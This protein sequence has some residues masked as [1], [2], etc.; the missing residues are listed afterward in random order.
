MEIYAAHY[1]QLVMKCTRVGLL[2]SPPRT[3]HPWRGLVRPQQ[4]PRPCR[5][6][7]RR[8][9]RASPHA[10]PRA[11]ML[12]FLAVHVRQRRILSRQWRTWRGR[13]WRGCAGGH[14]RT[15][16]TRTHPRRASPQQRRRG[17][18]GVRQALPAAWRD[19]GRDAYRAWRFACLGAPSPRHHTRTDASQ[20]LGRGASRLVA[21]P[22]WRPRG[23]IR[24]ATH[25]H[26]CR[27]HVRVASASLVVS[28]D[29]KFQIA[30]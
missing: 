19:L 9:V 23:G 7:A 1:A 29:T 16:R 8:L 28:S 18:P 2:R 12:H 27:H 25:E 24:A 5:S 10:L 30:R 22:R 4:P 21:T 3:H 13:A 6:A 11:L 15:T 17:G 14:A 20:D 26:R